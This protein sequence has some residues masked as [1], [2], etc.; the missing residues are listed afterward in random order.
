MQ[1]FGGG[2]YS[3][4]NPVPGNDYQ[5]NSW[6]SDKSVSSINNPDSV[7][8][9]YESRPGDDGKRGVLLL[10]FYA[11]RVTE[12]EWNTLKHNSHL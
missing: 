2:K 7:V 5:I 1:R 6:L 11:K 10:D 12:A 8:V 4:V 9:L 3:F